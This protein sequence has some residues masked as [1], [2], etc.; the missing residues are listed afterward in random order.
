M[1][2]NE[3]NNDIVFYMSISMVVLAMVS[4]VIFAFGKKFKVLKR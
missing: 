1:I 2:M 3:L 4:F